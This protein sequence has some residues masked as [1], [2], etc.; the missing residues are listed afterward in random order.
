MIKEIQL[1]SSSRIEMKTR[2]ESINLTT[3]LTSR[4]S[5]D[6]LLKL[7]KNKILKHLLIRNHRLKV[8]IWIHLKEGMTENYLRSRFQKILMTEIHLSEHLKGR[9]NIQQD[10]LQDLT[11]CLALLE[12]M[13]NL[14][15]T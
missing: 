11:P 14:K 12:R 6:L 2:W 5:M 1:I 13:E 10:F 9:V 15:M 8:I 4:V 3:L 7:T